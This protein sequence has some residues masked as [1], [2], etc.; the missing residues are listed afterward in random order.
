MT[1]YF[2]GGATT[3]AD[4]IGGRGRGVFFFNNTYQR[5]ELLVCTTGGL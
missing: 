1:F 3:M 5:L 2:T 4:E